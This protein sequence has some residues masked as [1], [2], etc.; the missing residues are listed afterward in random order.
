M[1]SPILASV[2][3]VRFIPCQLKR[4]PMWSVRDLFTVSD[5]NGHALLSCTAGNTAD[6]DFAEVVVS[7]KGGDHDLQSAVSIAFRAWAVLQDGIEERSEILSFIIHMEFCNAAS[8]GQ[9]RSIG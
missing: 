8:C 5:G 6:S 9:C 3:G 2:T 7:F 1:M 4:A